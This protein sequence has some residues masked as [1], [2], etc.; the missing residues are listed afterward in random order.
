MKKISTTGRREVQV[1]HFDLDGHVLS[2]TI[3]KVAR[4][5]RALRESQGGRSSIADWEFLCDV[6]D[7]VSLE[8]VQGRLDNPHDDF[9]QDVVQ[10]MTRHIVEQVFAARGAE[11]AVPTSEPSG[12]S[13][14]TST[15]G[16]ISTAPPP[17][18]ASTLSN[19]PPGG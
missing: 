5:M 7:T 10:E 14:G 8:H 9:D 18:P 12:S 16:T 6:L 3:P 4:V 13:P 11:P 19:F 15:N 2:Y 1:D 17:E